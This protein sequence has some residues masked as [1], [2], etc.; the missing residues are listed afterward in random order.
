MPISQLAEAP[1]GMG[2]LPDSTARTAGCQ[3]RKIYYHGKRDRRTAG[4]KPHQLEVKIGGEIDAGCD[5][6]NAW[7]AVLRLHV[8]RVLDISIIDWDV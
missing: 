2:L 6:K 4:K 1:K 5:G 3:K 7:D 8:P